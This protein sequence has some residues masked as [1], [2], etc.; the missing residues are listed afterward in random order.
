MLHCEILN[1]LRHEKP[2][3]YRNNKSFEF[4]KS[5][6]HVLS[7]NDPKARSIELSPRIQ[8]TESSLSGTENENPRQ[9]KTRGVVS[10]KAVGLTIIDAQESCDGAVLEPAI[11]NE[12][13]EL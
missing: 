2:E 7:T 3:K 9:Q 11:S 5:P 10:S 8:P 4:R 12:D 13:A 6:I 1:R